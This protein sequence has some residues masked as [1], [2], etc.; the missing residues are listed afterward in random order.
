MRKKD[1]DFETVCTKQVILDSSMKFKIKIMGRNIDTEKFNLK[2]NEITTIN[3]LEEIIKSVNERRVCSGCAKINA[4]E[5]IINSI[6]T[7]DK[8][9]YLRHKSCPFIL[10]TDEKNYM[11]KF[12]IRVRRTLNK[13]KRI[14]KRKERAIKY[15]KLNNL[16]P[17][18]K[19][20]IN[21]LKMKLHAEKRAKKR[22]K[23]HI[24][25]LKI[26][27]EMYRQELNKTDSEVLKKMLSNQENISN[28]ERSAIMAIFAA[29]EKKSEKQ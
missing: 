21:F 24:D 14:N 3:E 2:T 15:L 18:R 16:S 20:Q 9:G 8:E 27:V 19:R 13:K 6:T 1:T 17:E 22:A 10:E 25:E 12:C 4:E 5:N 11:C 26:E 28:N 29:A 7:R 23:E